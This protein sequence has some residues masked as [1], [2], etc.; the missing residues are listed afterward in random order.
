MKP[1]DTLPVEQILFPALSMDKQ[2]SSEIE[3]T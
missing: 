1:V 2:I 3:T